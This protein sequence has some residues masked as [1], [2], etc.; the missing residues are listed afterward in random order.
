MLLIHHH[1]HPLSRP[2]L[3]ILHQHVSTTYIHVTVIFVSLLQ[4]LSR[5]PLEANL[6]NL[7]LE[8]LPKFYFLNYNLVAMNLAH[9]YMAVSEVFLH[10]I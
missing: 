9:N 5:H 8:T 7:S 6:A 4:V 2:L 10:G 1:P 3:I